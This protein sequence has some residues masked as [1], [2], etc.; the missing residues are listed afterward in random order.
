MFMADQIAQAAGVSRPPDPPVILR[1]MMGRPLDFD[2][3]TRYAYSNFGYCVLG[4]VIEQITGQGYEALVKKEV[5]GPAGIKQMRIGSSLPDKVAP[6]EVHYYTIGNRK[7]PSV[8]A[9]ARD[10]VPLPDG[11]FCLESMDAHGGWIG[12]AVDLMRFVV[13][14]EDQRYGP[15]LPASLF[16]EMITPPPAPL[17]RK[18]DGAIAGVFYGCGWQVRRVN[19]SGGVNLWHTGSLPGTFTLMVRLANGLSWAVL[20]NQ[21]QASAKRPDDAIDAALHRAAAAVKEW[22]AK[23]LFVNNS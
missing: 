18:A 16:K 12:S 20:F 6:G 21:R 4:R 10:P 14:L 2:P 11:T 19:A 1:Y 5:L 7:G 15:L 22:P 13:A 3:G 17:A 8:F 23:D 9:E